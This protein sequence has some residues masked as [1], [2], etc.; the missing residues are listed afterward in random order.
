MAPCVRVERRD[1]HQAMHAGFGL[2]PSMRVVAL[3]EQG[4]GFEARFVARRLLD[5]LD[6]E[7]V[8]LGPSRIHAKQHARPIAALG[9]AGAGVNLDISVIGIGFAGQQRLD[10]T[11]LGFHLQGF[12]LA[13]AFLLGRRVLF[14]LGKLDQRDRVQK[15]TFETIE[16]AKP[17]LELG[18]L[19]HD[20][21]RGLGVVPR[22]DLRP[23]RSVRRGGERRLRRQ[24]C[25]LSNPI[26]C[27]MDWTSASASARILILTFQ[28]NWRLE[29]S[30]NGKMELLLARC[31]I[32]RSGRDV[33]GARPRQET[34]HGHCEAPPRASCWSARKT[35][36]G[37]GR[38]S[39]RNKSVKGED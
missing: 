23:W 3:D 1:A 36:A 28:G 27:W 35:R 5:D 14:R 39:Q 38:A 32:I 25:L 6:L 16:R 31:K 34:R 24:R 11:A 26:D 29:I 7:F 2:G 15:F 21:L 20:F 9:P 4:A 19:A 8:A 17:F 37:E 12:Q 30:F 33:N 18:T 13:E 10:L 22:L